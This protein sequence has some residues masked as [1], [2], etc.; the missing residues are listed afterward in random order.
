M[1]PLIVLLVFT[2]LARAVGALGVG[3]VASRPAATA[4]GLAAMFI[5][6]GA[7]HFL[8]ARRVGLIAIVPPAL[9][10]PAALVAFTGVLELLGAVAL[11]VPLEAGQLRVAAALSLAVLLFV[12]FPANVYASQARRSEHSPNTSLPQRTAM[13]CVFIAAT[14]FVALAS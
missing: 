7:S 11:L 12:M 14:L 4:V 3:Y 6:T 5:V 1:A 8:P 9:K 10:H 2:T 13:Q